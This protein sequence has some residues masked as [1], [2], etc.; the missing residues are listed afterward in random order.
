MDT[1]SILSLINSGGMLA[2][3]LIA[4]KLGLKGDIVS[5]AMLR[6]VVRI[7]IEELKADEEHVH[8]PFP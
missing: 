1:D 7:V 4:V 6:Q 3:L 5:R 2:L 8:P